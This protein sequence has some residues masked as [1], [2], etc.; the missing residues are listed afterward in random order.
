MNHAGKTIFHD[1]DGRFM[2]AVCVSA[3]YII[4]LIFKVAQYAPFMRGILMYF[5]VN[6]VPPV[7][8]QCFHSSECLDLIKK[9]PRLR[10]LLHC[11][12]T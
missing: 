4:Q 3:D 10:N 11:L 12:I 5:P 6:A 9:V 1:S 7:P 8:A 2:T